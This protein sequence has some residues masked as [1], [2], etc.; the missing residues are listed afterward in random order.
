MDGALGFSVVETDGVLRATNSSGYILYERVP[1]EH[2][3]IA[4]GPSNLMTHVRHTC[5]YQKLIT[6]QS[7][8]FPV[9]QNRSV[10]LV[11]TL[12]L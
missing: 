3:E 7:A 8:V 2:M 11:L 12:L 1:K 6:G 9:A 5:M 10:V 4:D